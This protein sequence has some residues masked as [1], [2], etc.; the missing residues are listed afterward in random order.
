MDFSPRC[1]SELEQLHKAQFPDAP[2]R[3]PQYASTAPDKKAEEH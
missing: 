2:A 1:W 3:S